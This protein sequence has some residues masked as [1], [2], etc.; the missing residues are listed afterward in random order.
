MNT[1]STRKS[2]VT[3]PSAGVFLRVALLPVLM[4]LF[5][6]N[7]TQAQIPYVQPFSL[8]PNLAP[9][10]AY[11]HNF[12]P[13]GWS[14]GKVSGT[15]SNNQWDVV[16]TGTL[17][18]VTPRSA[19]T[20]MRF[21]SFF[22]PNGEASFL[23]SKRLDMRAMPAAGAN[24]NFWFWRDNT[25][26]LTNAD[27][28]QVW[29]NDSALVIP[30]SPS[31]TMLLETSTSAGE[32]NR[33]CN[34]TPAAVTCNAWNQYSYTIPQTSGINNYVNGNVYVMI[35]GISAFGNNM[36]VDDFTINMW[37]NAQNYV[38]NSAAVVQ[39]NAATTAISAQNQMIIGC[40]MVMDGIT[41]PKVLTNM[42]FNTNGSSNPGTD[43]ASA[44][45][46][47][48]G[49]TSSFSSVNA[50]QLGTWT[51][52]GP[53][54]WASQYMFLTTPAAN[55]QAP[56][57]FNGLQQGDNYFWITYNIAGT[58]ISG[59]Y[60]DAEWNNFTFF[61]S[62]YQP[63]PQTLAGRRLIDLIYC[64]PN[65]GTGTAWAGYNTNDFINGVQLAGDPAAGA[66][67]QNHG[68][69]GSVLN[70]G[71]GT[72]NWI[73]TNAG[74]RCLGAPRWCAFQSHPPDYELFGASQTASITVN[75]AV[76]YTV[77]AQ[78]G[79]Y[80]SG[81][82]LA[83]WIDYNRDG[84]FNNLFDTVF[85][86]I[87]TTAAT[88]GTN[89][90]RVQ[91]N[92]GINVGMQV[93]GPGIAPG[94][95]VTAMANFNPF[96]ITLS[97]NNT[98]N[99]PVGTVIVFSN[100]PSSFPEKIL[101]SG[102][103]GAWGQNTNQFTVPS[104]ATPGKTRM[105]VREVWVSYNIDPCSYAT[106][107]EVEDYEVTVVPDCPGV[108]GYVTWL[109]FTS[110]WTDPANWCPPTVPVNPAT[111]N[112]RFPGGPTG[113]VYPYTKARIVSGV[114]ATASKMRIEAGDT[115][116]ID[117][118]TA[119]YLDLNDSLIIKYHPTTPLAS[120]ANAALI[121][122]TAFSDSAQ[123]MNG[124]AARL[125]DSPLKPALKTR[126]L[127][128][129][130]NA[131][132]VQE[133]FIDGDVGTAMRLHMRRLSNG[134]VYKNF[135][136]KYWWTGPATN[137]SGT[138]V[139]AV[140]GLPATPTLL[141]AGDLDVSSIPASGYGTI[142]L[143]LIPNAFIF[144]SANRRLVL[145]ISYDN[146]GFPLTG[147][148]GPNNDDIRFTGTQ[149][150][151]LYRTIS[152]NS[153]FP[154]TGENLL[155]NYANVGFT[156]TGTSG[157][158]VVTLN[159]VAGLFVGMSVV[160]AS[161]G[162]AGS[163]IIAIGP[164]NTVTL[165]NNSTTNFTS[166]TF[167][168]RHQFTNV[169]INFR[170][171]VTI[172]FERPY[173]RYPM[174]IAGHWQNN[175]VFTAGK[176]NVTF[177]GT[178]NQ[179][180]E[181]TTLTEYYN[182]YINNAAHVT[183]WTDFTVTDSLILTNGRLKL[184]NGLVTL[185][186]PQ[187][188]SLT[189]TNNGYIQADA[190][191]PTGNLAPYSRIRWNMGTTTGLRVIPFVNPAGLPVFLDYFIDSGTHDV[192][193]GT[194]STLANNT[195]IPTPDVT[196]ILGINNATGGGW[197][198]DGWAQVDRYYFMDGTAG[199]TPQADV[200]FRYA[201]GE[202]AQAGNISMKAQRWNNA[203]DIWEFPF[204]A[205]QTFTAGAPS[206]VKLDNYTAFD[207]SS[208]WTIVGQ[209]D[210]LPVSLLEF[211]AEKQIDKVKLIWSTS[212]E[213]N[214]SHFEIER[215]VNHDDYDFVSRVESQGP[216]NNLREYHTYDM[217][218]LNGVQYYYLRQVDYDGRT[219]RFGPVSATFSSD[220]FDIVTTTISP[221]D[222]GLTVVF[223]YN[224]TEPYSYRIM[225]MTGRIIVAKDRNAAV[226]GMNVIDINADL[227]KGAYHIILQNNSKVV[228]RKFFY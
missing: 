144:S 72:S 110:D 87:N 41:T 73:T 216:G 134:N 116:F 133:G 40:K 39:Q 67:I 99:I 126:S 45:L 111:P 44:T 124:A 176:S 63:N 162:L 141:Y 35:V 68:G 129:I 17:P 223:N 180:I 171:N 132:L 167:S 19:S 228:S 184:N 34:L 103:L 15:A 166:T 78:T 207:V 1:S 21:Q 128:L 168:V 57:S 188:T 10:A 75:N 85:L 179:K 181:G 169:S 156:G 8:G 206:S 112:I 147:T 192:T 12:L 138:I 2:I 98:A 76:P 53:S 214:N 25:G 64:V 88:A 217:K 130:D 157:S 46:W 83:A 29:V 160:T 209:A 42:E 142:I 140:S 107:G 151:F 94:A 170:P 201:A 122:N 164:G 213:I 82:A 173:Q 186:N 43:I 26:Y 27:R 120:Q 163:Q 219:E 177:D 61:P 193:L 113:S 123:L 6:V 131:D 105:R 205:A 196:N 136:V 24:F 30:G 121:I 97:V 175:G 71:A 210:P 145:D 93:A 208:W 66:G 154:T 197:G 102:P 32:I 37:G 204:Y 89:T 212:S 155:F 203:T 114:N 22:I 69:F 77:R 165:N 182:L 195:N 51:P 20:M 226:D 54:P 48:S 56:A 148:I 187:L 91:N 49:G 153:V 81:N 139:P 161:G 199:A 194:Y 143:P 80:G 11:P 108:A 33:S 38:V 14:Q 137:V 178:S 149:S 36:F 150:Q 3:P 62:T 174:R 58:A 4:L 115:V 224:S 117:A 96:N 119:S 183:R 202:N 60:V 190:D 222:R 84:T 92:Y 109:G 104:W 5:L 118:P 152:T 220:I 106:Y 215:T 95:V 100:P 127:I 47:W 135:K 185:T 65:Y 9:A 13:V 146:T 18:T 189:R 221:T 59:N 211:R 55:G 218:P 191:I 52:N 227:A 74:S 28:I 172:E 200:T 16:N 159:S 158:N 86:N 31:N 79:D 23:A 225:D 125:P 101:Q 50:Q 90:I 198:T 7:S 70:N